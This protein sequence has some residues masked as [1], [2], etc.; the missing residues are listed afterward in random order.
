MMPLGLFASPGFRIALP[1]GFAFVAGNY[2][3]VFATSL[4]LRQYL[5]LSPLRRRRGRHRRPRL[6][7]RRVTGLLPG[8]RAGLAGAAAL[9]LATALI[10][11]RVHGKAAA[12]A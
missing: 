7:D 12:G 9:L 3:N 11:L 1:V 4:F 2:G 5:G 10:S 8:L 6:A